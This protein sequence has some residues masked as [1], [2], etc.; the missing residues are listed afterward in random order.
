[1]SWKSMIGLSCA[2]VAALAALALAAWLRLPADAMLPIHW[3][4]AVGRTDLPA[5]ASRSRCRF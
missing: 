2:V 3:N 4:A 5:P 1:M